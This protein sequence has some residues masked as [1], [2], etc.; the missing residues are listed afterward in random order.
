MCTEKM[1]EIC[2]QL[3]NEPK[4]NQIFRIERSSICLL[5]AQRKKPIEN[6]S[7]DKLQ[8]T[9]KLYHTS[10]ST[11]IS[12]STLINIALLCSENPQQGSQT[13]ISNQ[14]LLRKYFY[15]LLFFALSTNP[16]E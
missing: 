12:I 11:H 10:S 6:T 4:N 15:D 3:L 9:H 5:S 8:L 16:S 7:L 1:N 2:L 14:C 13:R